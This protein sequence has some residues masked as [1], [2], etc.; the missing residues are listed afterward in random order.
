MAA[1]ST[2]TTT[3]DTHR[4]FATN[5][6]NSLG[7]DLVCDK[8]MRCLPGKEK[9][10]AAGSKDGCYLSQRVSGHSWAGRSCRESS[11]L[12]LQTLRCRLRAVSMRDFP[13]G[14]GGLAQSQS[15]ERKAGSAAL[16][17]NGR[18]QQ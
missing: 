6:F 4:L 15:P 5:M 1:G 2:A 13:K 3:P 10:E 12:K 16:V 14:R 9:S 8:K 11:E 7:F 18:R 17:R